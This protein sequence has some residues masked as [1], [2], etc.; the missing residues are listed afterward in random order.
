MTMVG[1]VC[2]EAVAGMLPRTSAAW[3]THAALALTQQ[4]L[5]G[6]FCT[7][8]NSTV[9]KS[10]FQPVIYLNCMILSPLPLSYIISHQGKDGKCYLQ[11]HDLQRKP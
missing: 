7:T 6:N 1:K 2:S 5:E 4:E 8:S 3:N 9:S 10:A 11:G